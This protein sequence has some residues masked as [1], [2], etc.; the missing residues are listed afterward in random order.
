M[1]LRATHSVDLTT[2]RDQLA[3]LSA[4]DPYMEG[5]MRKKGATTL[6]LPTGSNR[7]YFELKHNVLYWWK[8][9]EE[10]HSVPP[11]GSIDCAYLITSKPD[12]ASNVKFSLVVGKAREYQFECELAYDR[13]QWLTALTSAAKRKDRPFS[14]LEKQLE[15]SSGR[16]SPATTS[17]TPGISPASTS[18]SLSSRT[19]DKAK[20][21]LPSV[22]AVSS[23]HQ[24]PSLQPKAFT[25]PTPTAQDPSQSQSKYHPVPSFNPPPVPSAGVKKPPPPPPEQ[26]SP[27]SSP[28]S[29]VL[30]SQPPPPAAKKPLPPACP[31]PITPQSRTVCAFADCGQ[32]RIANKP[33]CANHLSK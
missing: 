25:A 10:K 28:N 6:G 15:A 7:R 11:K 32:F 17:G 18:R 26:R 4:F 30:V 1:S 14:L 12:P 13:H 22:V 24:T 29:A 21:A 8:S 19:H 27:V 31:R 3:A 16:T 2:Y 9:K 20:P 5:Y 33:Y 23:S